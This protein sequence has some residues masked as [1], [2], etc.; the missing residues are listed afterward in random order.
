MDLY[1][2]NMAV[3]NSRMLRC[4]QAEGRV[5]RRWD[6]DFD[7]RPKAFGEKVTSGAAVVS[8]VCQKASHGAVDLIQKIWK[9]CR[10]ADVI[11]G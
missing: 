10:I 9:C 8:P 6:R 1:F 3:T 4:V 2:D 11:R 5:L 7:R